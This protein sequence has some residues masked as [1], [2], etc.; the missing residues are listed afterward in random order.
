M[1][2]KS[3]ILAFDDGK[4]E[5]TD[6]LRYRKNEVN[7]KSAKLHRTDL[8]GVVTKGLQLMHVSNSRITVDGDD[9]TTQMLSIFEQN[10][11]RN[12]IQIILIDSP[13][14]AGFNI[15]DPFIIHEM[16][17]IPV[18]LIPSNPPTHI[19]AEVFEN[20][21]P[22]RKEDLSILKNLPPLEK[23]EVS[24]NISPT[25]KKKLCFHPIG[26]SKEEVIDLL[27]FL[28][29]FSAVPEPLRLAHL[30]AS[31]SRMNI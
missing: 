20:I 13:T 6:L 9:A 4:H 28:T 24:V 1:K 16:S 2:R 10:P 30:I 22:D 21:F 7:Q 31:R 12:E 25:I 8:I 3:C 17:Q 11:F 26:I 29:H 5:K 27:N 14:V 18:L 19:I 15:P 23:I